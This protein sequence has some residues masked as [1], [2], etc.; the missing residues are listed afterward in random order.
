MMTPADSAIEL[1]PANSSDIRMVSKWLAGEGWDF[2]IRDFAALLRNDPHSTLLVRHQSR[3]LGCVRAFSIGDTLGRISD[4]VIHPSARDKGL[5]RVLLRTAMSR[6]EGKVI[7][8]DSPLEW[9]STFEKEGFTTSFQV[10]RYQILSACDYAASDSVTVLEASMIPAVGQFERRYFNA[11]RTGYLASLLQ[12]PVTMGRVVMEAGEVKGYAL[13]RP[14]LWGWKIGP[15]VAVSLDVAVKLV[16]ALA[17]NLPLGSK[18]YLDVPEGNPEMVELM[19]RQ[20]KAPL[21]RVARMYNGA[22]PEIDCKGIYSTACFDLGNDRYCPICKQHSS[23]FA[24]FG[25]YPR[26]DALCPHCGSLE[27]HRLLW[28]ILERHPDLFFKNLPKRM[29]H[30]APEQ[31]IRDK[32]RKLLG[33]R[34]ITSDICQGAADVQMD[35]CDIKLPDG[36]FDAIMCNHVLEHVPDDLKAM[37]E[38]RRVLT[39]G[40]IAF[41]MVPVTV[42][43]TF[44]DPSITD[45]QERLRVFGQI[46]H[47][48]RYGVDFIDRLRSVGFQVECFTPE[49]VASKSEVKKMRMSDE[50]GAAVYVCRK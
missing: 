16:N 21:L 1:T 49:K 20:C 14:S 19:N 2:G 46:D 48:R 13:M 35:I 9:V 15:L 26:P 32:F 23:R 22:S 7:G 29:L 39:P 36:S 8:L 18:V 44:E 37:S 4:L 12:E 6:L 33:N 30:V 28:L 34:Y 42:E 41:I 40:G 10:L 27:R 47:V 45:P 38:L 25:V 11:D 31:I 50:F 3:P 24:S 5:G 17:T 43:K